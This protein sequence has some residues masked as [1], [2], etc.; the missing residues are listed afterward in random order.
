MKIEYVQFVKA[1]RMPHGAFE[2]T[3][4][5]QNEHQRKSLD[6]AVSHTQRE[7]QITH[8]H[9]GWTFCVPFE[10]V[11]CYWEDGTI[12]SQRERPR[13]PKPATQ[14]PTQPPIKRNRRGPRAR[15]NP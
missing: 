12:E 4:S 5:I 15:P 10:N 14:T 7:I 1:V 6:L 3:V 2:D 8:K 11:A 13:P 9:K